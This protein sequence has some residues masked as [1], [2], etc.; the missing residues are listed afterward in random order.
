[1]QGICSHWDMWMFQ[2][3]GLTNHQ[4]L[5]TATIHGARALGLDAHVGSL[6]AGKL[7]DLV[8]LDSNPLE[9]IRSSE[10][11]SMVVANG[12]LYD[13]RTLAQIHPDKVPAPVLPPLV[14]AHELGTGCAEHVVR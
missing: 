12:R 1:M 6:R 13:A 9:D 7:A 8:V 5:Q 3:G 10:D 14:V 4:A 2:Q 11:I